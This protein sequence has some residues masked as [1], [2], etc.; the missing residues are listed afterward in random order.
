MSTANQ[1]VT[2][3]DSNQNTYTD[4]VAQAQTT[5]GHQIHIF[6][7]PNVAGGNNAVTA[8]FS[9]TNKHPW[10]AIYEYS[11]LNIA[12]PL[13][14][15]AHAQGSGSVVST[16]PTATTTSTNELVVAGAGFVNNYNGTVIAGSGYTLQQQDTGTSRAANEG[17][18]GSSIGAYAGTFSLSSSTNW[19]AVVATFKP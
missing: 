19:S 17:G 12:A 6:Y 7:A 3:T 10:L 2:V 15:T 8:T 16:G 11:G 4:A 13:D 1:T 9:G 14:K 5:D 18:V